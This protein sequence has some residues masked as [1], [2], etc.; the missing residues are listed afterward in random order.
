MPIRKRVETKVENTSKGYR[1]LLKSITSSSRPLTSSL[2]DS[3]DFDTEF[4]DGE[5]TD[6]SQMRVAYN[7]KAVLKFASEHG[8]DPSDLTKEQ[9]KQ[10][11]IR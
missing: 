7:F 4:P 11:E 8:I 1:V 10:F 9:M 2:E 6:E 5:Y 3:A